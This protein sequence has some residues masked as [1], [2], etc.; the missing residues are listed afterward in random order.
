MSTTTFGQGTR[1]EISHLT[2]RYPGTVVPA[3]DDVSVTVAAGEFMTFL[4][5]S[6][7]GKTTTLNMVAGFTDITSGRIVLG[8][9]DVSGLP[10]HRRDLGMVFQQYAL[11]PH[12]TVEQNI[13]FPLKQ[14]KT[15][16]AEITRRVA[17]ALELV[18][19]SEYGKRY[20]S[21]LSGGQQQRVALARAVV[22][23]PRALLL[24]E[25]LG[26][27]D[28]KLRSTLQDEVRR[29]HRE[30]GLTFVFVTHDQEEALALSDR[31]AVFNAGGIEQVGTP[32]ELYLR[33]A[34]LFVAEFLGESNV[35]HGTLD[36]ARRAYH[37][38]GST[39][40]APS[41]ASDVDGALLVRP[42]RLQLNVDSAAVPAEHNGLSVRVVSDI[43]L[44]THH[45]VELR[46]PDG[47]TGSA[48]VPVS[49]ARDFRPGD[50]VHASWAPE[51]Q[52]VV[53]VPAGG[54]GDVPGAAPRDGLAPPASRSATAAH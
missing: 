9:E 25:P 37:W 40:S 15:P 17:E 49:A 3:V 47:S 11:F 30:L 45:K 7:S 48:M 50:L 54:P 34:T 21:A 26:A 8:D 10:P 23:A 36:R 28:R 53:A 20:P 29:M 16:A 5:P 32:E 52:S 22:F 4:G 51:D 12:M 2:K 24:D 33:P 14:R 1:I 43:F 46:M 13:A 39:W 27:L 6:G 31:I 38:Q 18:H 35:F 42:E 19:L 44:G 41:A